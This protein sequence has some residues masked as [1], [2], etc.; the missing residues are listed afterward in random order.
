M[1]TASP[2]RWFRLYAEFA[3]DPKVQMLS[4]TDQRRYIMLLCLR[5]SN[6]NV[7]L[8]D[9]EVAFQLRISIDEA[10]DTKRVLTEKGLIC[11]AWQPT[12]WDVRQFASD[13]SADRVRKHRENA[14]LNAASSTGMHKVQRR[15]VTVTTPETETEGETESEEGKPSRRSAP[16]PYDEII[17]LYM[18]T[19][20]SLPRVLVSND[21]RKRLIKKRWSWILTSKKADGTRRAET[22]EQ[23]LDWLRSYFERVSTNQFLMGD[24][25]RG[26]KA[27]IDYLMEDRGLKAVIERTQ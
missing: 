12:A 23:A 14:K 19:L 22:P 16:C 27:D 7:T 15:N 13:S 21:K 1:R 9:S 4:E 10:L 3:H 18:E 25:D 17:N 6:G 2:A 24:N 26:W 20:P 11:N 8:Q 5:C